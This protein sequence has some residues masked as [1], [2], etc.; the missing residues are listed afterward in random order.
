MKPEL[1]VI[2]NTRYN[3]ETSL[4]EL[5]DEIEL[6]KEAIRNAEEAL[7]A[8]EQELDEELYARYLKDRHET[9]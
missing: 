1:K 2:K 3:P 8:A 7:K 9:V 4:Q 5:Y 6:Y